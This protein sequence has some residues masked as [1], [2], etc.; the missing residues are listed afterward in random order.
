MPV[1]DGNNPDGWVFRAKRF[2]NMNRLSEA[3]KLD[4][5]CWRK[6]SFAAEDLAQVYNKNYINRHVVLFLI[7][8]NKKYKGFRLQPLKPIKSSC[9]IILSL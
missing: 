4:A 9:E 8:N 6:N 5:A 1:F 7:L 2:F 3:E